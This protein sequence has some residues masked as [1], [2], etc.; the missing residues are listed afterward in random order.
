MTEQEF[1]KQKA[2]MEAMLAGYEQH[3]ATS[4]FPMTACIAEMKQMIA[5]HFEKWEKQ[6]SVSDSKSDS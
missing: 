1:L 3:Q 4:G 5:R 2:D 6:N